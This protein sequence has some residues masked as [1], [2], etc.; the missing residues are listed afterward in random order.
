[1]GDVVRFA[2]ALVDGG[3]DVVHGHSSHHPRPLEV[4]RGRVVLYG[5]G[6]LV[7]DYE[8]I[9]GYEEYRPDL[10]VLYV[11]DL[12]PG[13]GELGRLR[14]LPFRAHRLTLE[15]GSVEDARWL[16]TALT[17]AGRPFGTHLD[18]VEGGRLE[19]RL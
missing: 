4:Y 15:R 5:C 7:N 13:T 16:A 10:R 6:D 1:V 17:R 3:V 12:D 8:G 11:A 2:H 14:L 19:V 18:V 9:P